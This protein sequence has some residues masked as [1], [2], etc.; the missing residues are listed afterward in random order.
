M[1]HCLPLLYA[2]ALVLE[3]GRQAYAKNL[4]LRLTWTTAAADSTSVD[5]ILRSNDLQ[6]SVTCTVAEMRVHTWAVVGQGRADVAAVRRTSSTSWYVICGADNRIY[7][8][9]EFHAFAGKGDALLLPTITQWGDWLHFYLDDVLSIRKADEYVFAIDWA[10]QSENKIEMVKRFLRC[11]RARIPELVKLLVGRPQCDRS[12]YTVML[13]WLAVR[14]LQLDTEALIRLN[15]H[16]LSKDA[17][18]TYMN[19]LLKFLR[20]YLDEGKQHRI[21][22]ITTGYASNEHKFSNRTIIELVNPLCDYIE[23]DSII[24][25]FIQWLKNRAGTQSLLVLLEYAVKGKKKNE[26]KEVFQATG[27]ALDP[28][29][30]GAHRQMRI[31]HFYKGGVRRIDPED[32]T[33]SMIEAIYRS[34][35]NTFDI[36]A[37]VPQANTPRYEVWV[38]KQPSGQSYMVKSTVTIKKNQTVSM[39]STCLYKFPD[40]YKILKRYHVD[41][42]KKE[43]TTLMW[44]QTDCTTRFA[45]PLEKMHLIHAVQARYMAQ[46]KFTLLHEVCDKSPDR[47]RRFHIDFDGVNMPPM[48]AARALAK[49]LH[50]RHGASLETMKIAIT[51]ALPKKPGFLW[52]HLIVSGAAVME[53]YDPTLMLREQFHEEMCAK[54][55]TVTTWPVNCVDATTKNLRKFGADKGNFDGRPSIWGGLY[56]AKDDCMI[57]IENQILRQQLCSIFPEKDEPVLHI[58]QE[59]IDAHMSKR[60]NGNNSNNNHKNGEGDPFD[61]TNAKHQC[62]AAEVNALVQQYGLGPAAIE[63][64]QDKSS[65]MA[66]PQ[67][68]ANL[69]TGFCL[70]L[71]K[72]ITSGS[73]S[74]LKRTSP[75]EHI[76]RKGC[77]KFRPRGLMP[78]CKDTD[79]SKIRRRVGFETFPFSFDETRQTLFPVDIAYDND[80]NEVAPSASDEDVRALVLSVFPEDA[81]IWPTEEG[82][83][84]SIWRLGAY[85]GPSST[86][87]VDYCRGLFSIVRREKTGPK[88]PVSC[89]VRQL[90]RDPQQVQGIEFNENLAREMMEA[91]EKEYGSI[92]CLRLHA[93][94]IFFYDKTSGTPIA[95]LRYNVSP[96]R[97]KDYRISHDK[98]THASKHIERVCYAFYSSIRLLPI[99]RMVIAESHK[100]RWLKV[101]PDPRNFV[102]DLGASHEKLN[103]GLLEPRSDDNP[104]AD[105]LVGP[106]GISKTTVI[107]D[108]GFKGHVCTH[109]C[110]LN[111]NLAARFGIGSYQDQDGKVRSARELAEETKPF[112]FV[113]NSIRNVENTR[114]RDFFADEITASLY[115]ITGE[116]MKG[117]GPAA[118]ASLSNIFTKRVC[119]PIAASADITP[120]LEGHY[121]V[122]ML[123]LDVRVLYKVHG[124]SA[125]A[126]ICIELMSDAEFWDAVTRVILHNAAAASFEAC[127]KAYIPCTTA[128]AV[129]RVRHLCKIHWP[130]GEHLYVCLHAATRMPEHFLEK[131]DDTWI[132][133]AIVCVSTTMKVG[134]SMEKPHFHLTLA[135]ATTGCGTTEDVNQL[136]QRPRVPAQMMLIRINIHG[137]GGKGKNKGQEGIIEETE[138]AL[139][140][141]VVVNRINRSVLPQQPA[142]VADST[143]PH[144]AWLANHVARYTRL[145]QINFLQNVRRDLRKRQMTVRL[146]GVPHNQPLAFGNIVLQPLPPGTDTSGPDLKQD[147][148]D[149]ILAA[150][151]IDKH[152]LHALYEKPKKTLEEQA[153]IDR[154]KIQ[155]LYAKGGPLSFEELVTRHVKDKF[156]EQV[157]LASIALR[158]GDHGAA[159]MDEAQRMYKEPA[160]RTHHLKKRKVVRDFLAAAAPGFDPDLFL[161][162]NSEFKV[163]RQQLIDANPLPV[164]EKLIK[165]DTLDILPKRA[166]AADPIKRIIGYF[167]SMAEKMDQP[168]LVPTKKVWR[169]RNEQKKDKDKKTNK[170]TKMTTE[171][172][173]RV[174]EPKIALFYAG[175]NTALIDPIAA[176]VEQILVYH[177]VIFEDHVVDPA[178]NK[179]YPIAPMEQNMMA[180]YLPM[181]VDNAANGFDFSRTLKHAVCSMAKVPEAQIRCTMALFHR[182]RLLHVIFPPALLDSLLFVV[183]NIFHMDL[184]IEPHSP[185]SNVPRPILPTWCLS[186]CVRLSRFGAYWIIEDESGYFIPARDASTPPTAYTF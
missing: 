77:I 28:L 34:L 142:F 51:P 170:R 39:E 80:N 153:Q 1:S 71:N 169:K 145:D 75:F 167:N 111:A 134:V 15:P 63:S 30:T 95:S 155:E 150:P 136:N 102:I 44:M 42:K 25:G 97:Y 186:P 128:A 171:W 49:F 126:T 20:E 122:N 116:T 114:I 158:Q 93:D 11:S 99:D 124:P 37:V 23:H 89:E 137:G 179:S 101:L 2:V 147:H 172:T 109:S 74:M 47:L 140:A 26:K 84:T 53:G 45:L 88:N 117:K 152:Q 17:Q 131:P 58:L 174:T 184:H 36:I 166:T 185:P 61:A 175:I 120:E 54:Y 144:Y 115:S 41:S 100:A 12:L 176:P 78:F 73:K 64:I 164:L 107:I 38:E 43:E 146:G 112:G 92:G 56:S 123:K 110:A 127:V 118:L 161:N 60:D 94:A 148:I 76:S 22:R 168:G 31:I 68:V 16:L 67:W 13:K 55:D 106:P 59:T 133:Y 8:K 143:D 91:C 10:K 156:Q 163:T 50:Q 165:E 108:S 130:A 96:P 162:P 48:D 52:Y 138:Q 154:Y 86:Y 18:Q 135:Y 160:D 82:E 85:F 177:P 178:T 182:R 159:R 139:A 19:T 40:L 183:T 29:A 5:A 87:K 113:I 6:P 181:P 149:R 27:F 9:V 141:Y 104:G 157:E 125:S 151:D 46:S 132:K 79:C 129:E 98:S 4:A 33:L 35:P 173:M 66:D 105:L 32:A 7:E 57:H 70:A 62:I 24:L 69:H 21:Q 3:Q 83:T 180:V 81:N 14:L 103:Y 65:D 72:Q 121:F 90:P 119:N